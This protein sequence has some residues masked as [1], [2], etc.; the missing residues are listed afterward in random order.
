MTEHRRISG[1]KEI[2]S[3]NQ[4][5]IQIFIRNISLHYLIEYKQCVQ[6]VVVFGDTITRIFAIFSVFHEMAH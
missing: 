2:V 5:V 4:I 3:G 6:I 1:L